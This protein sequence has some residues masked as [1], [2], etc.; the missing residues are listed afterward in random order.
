MNNGGRGT[1]ETM[2][3][4]GTGGIVGSVGTG[5]TT[6]GAGTG[7]TAVRRSWALRLVWRAVRRRCRRLVSTSYDWGNESTLRGAGVTVDGSVGTGVVGTLSGAAL[8]PGDSTGGVL[9]GAMDS[10][11]GTTTWWRMLLRVC[12]AATVLG[13]KGCSVEWADG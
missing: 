11:G 6:V 2:G 4:I 12:N 1:V 5:G 7:V 9:D 13:C 8:G 10:V 3:R